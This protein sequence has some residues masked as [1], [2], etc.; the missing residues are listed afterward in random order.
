MP[1]RTVSQVAGSRAQTLD[2]AVRLASV[3]GLEGLT[4]GGLAERLDMSK[5]GLV[6]RF[7][8]KQE[9][10]LAAL[11]LAADVFTRTVYEPA[12]KEPHGLRRLKAIC[13]AWIRYLAD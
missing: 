11:E 8:S 7:G 13:D 3:V 2:T 6:G 10:Q 12:T 4:I 1:R 5:S 9:L